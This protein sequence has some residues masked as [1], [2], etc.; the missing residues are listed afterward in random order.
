M[1]GKQLSSKDKMKVVEAKLRNPELS[2]RDI[3]QETWIPHSSAKNILDEIPW[4]CTTMDKWAILI[5]TLDSIIYDIAEI[6]SLSMSNFKEKVMNKELTTSDIK[7]L[8]E[9]AKNNFDRKQILEWKPTINVN[10]NVSEIKEMDN[11]KLNET[12]S[13]LLN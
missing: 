13:T 10:L 2:L 3:E 7:W 9:V 1:K 11:E 8:N 6:T 5:N 12:V 4:V